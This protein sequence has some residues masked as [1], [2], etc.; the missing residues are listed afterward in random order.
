MAIF[1]LFYA[2]K[3]QTG[4][5]IIASNVQFL[6]PKGSDSEFDSHEA[7]ISNDSKQQNLEVEEEIPF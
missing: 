2:H 3:T 6:S 4:A 7:V 1:V 5:E